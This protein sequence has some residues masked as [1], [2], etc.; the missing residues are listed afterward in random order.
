MWPPPPFD[1][2]HA[3]F[4]LISPCLSPISSPSHPPLSLQ[5]ITPPTQHASVINPHLSHPGRRQKSFCDLSEA[6]R[7]ENLHFSMSNTQNAAM[8]IKRHNRLT[9]KTHHIIVFNL[10]G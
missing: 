10:T 5:L 6:R 4:L 9:E 8:L 3:S 1:S 7:N 2:L